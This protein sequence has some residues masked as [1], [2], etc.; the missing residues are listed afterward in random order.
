MPKTII[1]FI[2]SPS[3][4]DS[5]LPQEVIQIIKKE[6]KL[7]YIEEK[8]P[9]IKKY[10]HINTQYCVACIPTKNQ[11]LDSLQDFGAKTAKSIIHAVPKNEHANIDIQFEKKITQQEK[12]FLSK[13]VLMTQQRNDVFKSKKQ[14]GDIALTGI[15]NEKIISIVD[16]INI[17]RELTSQPSNILGPDEIESYV[18]TLVKKD[19]TLRLNILKEKDL[20]KEKMNMQLAVNAGSPKEA[21]L[22]C[23]EYNPT[24]SKEAPILLVGKGLMYDSGGYYAKP[25]PH[26]GDMHGDMGGAASVIA[27]MAVL[28]R[29][30]IKKRI[31]GVCGIAENMIDAHAYRNGDILTSRKGKTVEVNHTDAEGRLVLADVLSYCEDT[32]KP[33]LIFDFATLTGA[34]INALGEMYTAIFSDNK[35]LIQTFEKIGEEVNDKVWPLP[36]DADIKKAVK[37]DIADLSNTSKLSGMLGASTAAAFLSN[38]VNDTKKWVHFDIAGS[39]HRDKMKKEYDIKNL[40]GTGSSVHLVLEYLER[41]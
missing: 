37:G 34:T 19:K 13:G 36:F 27:I 20:K 22:L 4:S 28:S 23:I 26:M 15:A 21:R 30:K 32:Y 2:K 11:T 3:F 9:F 1:T 25:Y 8:K 18:K 40:L 39:A 5:Q 35:K 17:A 41:S 29:M 14:Y 24:K 31:I 33:E 12:D 16:A 7:K 6:V 38:F 10:I